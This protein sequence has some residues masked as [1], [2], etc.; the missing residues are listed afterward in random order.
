M[1]RKF[2]SGQAGAPPHRDLRVAPVEEASGNDE[3]PRLRRQDRQT[4]ALSPTRRPNIYFLAAKL[5]KP[6]D[7]TESIRGRARLQ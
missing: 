5:D 7:F 6:Y 1:L 3:A 4:P 2:K